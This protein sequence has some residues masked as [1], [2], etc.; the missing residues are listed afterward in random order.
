MD[1]LFNELGLVS[2]LVEGLKKENIVTPTTIQEKCIP[3]ALEN[4]DIIAQ[5]ETGSGKTLAYLLPIFQKMDVT[6][7]EMQTIIL[8]PTHELA[9]QIERQ[10][11]LLSKNS[12]IAVTSTPIIGNVNITRQIDK[13]KEKPHIIVGSAGRILELIKKKKLSAHTIKT[14]VIDEADRLLD[15][16][17]IDAVKAIIKSTLKERQLIIVS[18]TISKEAENIAKNLMK[19]PEY[20]KVEESHT[21]S[22]N[23]SHM[24]FLSDQREKFDNLRKL[25]RMINPKKAIVFINKSEEI[26]MITEK[27]KYNG[28]KAE[29][30]HGTSMKENRK[31]AMDEFRSGK[32]QLLVASDVAARGLDIKEVTHIF[33]LDM[34]QDPKNYLHR[35]GRTG[36][37]GESGVAISLITEQEKDIINRYEKSFGIN[38]S[39]KDMYLG[40]IVDLKPPK[41][42]PSTFRKNTE[43]SSTSKTN[44]LT[45]EKQYKSTAEKSNSFN[46]DRQDRPSFAKPGK[47]KP[48]KKS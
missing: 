27:L 14:I 46:K 40:K 29:G 33:N 9:I 23:I 4:K 43:A 26:A 44:N 5:S 31:K 39:A 6:K 48:M 45:K 10:I 38:I 11:E 25:V 3:A 28:F 18:A 16:H 34:P 24:Y 13:L 8:T 15:M 20:L 22:T 42:K 36:R 35:V 1:N 17:N 32:I 7:K 12:G 19:D 41:R 30:I 47:S 37:A 21:I 2:A